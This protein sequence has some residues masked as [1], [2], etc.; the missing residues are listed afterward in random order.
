MAQTP[1]P[2]SDVL[3]QALRLP[4][5]ERLRLIE[6]VAAS[7]ESE[8]A[9]PERL[10]VTEHWGKSLNALLDSLDMSDWERIEDPAAWLKQVRETEIRDR[11]GDWGT[12]E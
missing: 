8:M 6:Q 11:V 2:L 1:S 9:A 5:K 7:V 4:A 12:D 3:A 10:P